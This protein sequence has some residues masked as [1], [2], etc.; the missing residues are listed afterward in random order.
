MVELGCGVAPGRKRGRWAA[1]L[2]TGFPLARDAQP[3]FRD[4]P[5]LELGVVG[6]SLFNLDGS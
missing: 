2:A 1:G 5:L 3:D 6:G 4:S